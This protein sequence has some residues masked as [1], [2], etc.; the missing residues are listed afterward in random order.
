MLMAIVKEKLKIIGMAH[1]NDCDPNL[2][3]EYLVVLLVPS[4]ILSMI[5][6]GPHRLFWP[7]PSTSGHLVADHS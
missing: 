5:R 6:G 7:R 4:F 3:L 1:N 2:A